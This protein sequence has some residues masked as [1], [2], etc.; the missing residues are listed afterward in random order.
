M[1]KAE[2][3]PVVGITIGRVNRPG[4]PDRLGLDP[5]YVAALE[6]AGA[7]CVLLPPGKD[8]PAAIDHVLSR[9]DGVLIP[10]GAD[11][12]P[13]FY[14]EERHAAVGHTDPE[15]DNYEIRV[16]R[17]AVKRG[18]PVL[19]ICRGQ[20]SINVALGGTLYQDLESQAAV[21]ARHQ[22]PRGPRQNRLVHG[23]ELKDG[24]RYRRAA[25]ARQV[26]VNS[27]HHQAVRDV[28]PGLVVSALSRDG[29]IEGLES[30]D[31]RVVA[32]QCHPEAM[33]QLTWARRLF[34]DFVASAQGG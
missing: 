12:D 17:A 20:Q 32:V 7:R 15:R 6:A 11:V 25:G 33:T 24:T 9:L 26:R 5:K 29:V 30:P 8:T 27:R 23:V 19:G 22:T 16:I 13:R 31:G 18:M 4:D 28:A 10:G 2:N 21:R 34:R 1:R 3:D 14:G